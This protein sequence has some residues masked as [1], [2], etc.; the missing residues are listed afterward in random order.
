MTFQTHN[1]K[2]KV[3]KRLALFLVAAFVLAAASAFADDS[4]FIRV[5]KVDG[6]WNTDT[7][8]AGDTAKFYVM[9][10]NRSSKN[11]NYTAAFRVY[12]RA[13]KDAGAP[14]SGTAMWPSVF[15]AGVPGRIVFSSAR[16]RS[17]P[18]VDTTGFLSKANFGAVNSFN[19]FGCDGQ[20]V[21]TVGITQ[22]ANDIEQTAIAPFDS[23]VAYKFLIVTRKEDNGKAICFDSANAYP[24]TNTWKWAPFNQAPGTPNAF[25]DWSGPHCYWLFDPNAQPNQ[26]PVLAPIGSQNVNENQ[27]LVVVANANDPDGPTPS[28]TASPLPAGAGFVDNGNGTAQLT[29]TPT[30]SQSGVYNV[31]FVASDGQL[32]DS[33]LVQITV[34]NVNRPP[35]LD[36]IGPQAVNEGVNLTFGISGT[37]PDGGQLT[38]GAS[39][40]PTGA[41]F[42]GV[43]GT[44]SWTPA[45][46]QAGVYNVNFF[47]SDGVVADTELVQITVNNVNRPPVLAA[48][49]AKNATV[50]VNLSFGVSGSD[51]DGTIPALSAS[52]LA[53]AN[54]TDNGDGTGTFSF[55]PDAGQIGDHNVT[56]VASDGSLAD[57]EVVTITVTGV[58]NDAPTLDPIGSKT[59]AEGDQLQFFISGTDPNSDPLTFSTGPLPTGASFQAGAKSFFWQPGYDQAGVYNVL[60]IVSDGTLSDS[61]LVE[62]TVTNTNRPPVLAAI[63]AKS[64]QVGGTLVFN[65]A[66]SDVDGTIP[67]LSASALANA[68]LTDNGNGT[69]SYSFTPDA[70]Q[71]GVHN[72]TFVASDG[73]LADSE[74]VEITVTPKSDFVVVDKDTLM[75][76]ATINSNPPTQIV[77][78]TK[79]SDNEIDYTASATVT[80]IEL[81]GA[82]GTTPG[83]LFVAI[84]TSGLDVGSYHDSVRVQGTTGPDQWIQVYLTITPCPSVQVSKAVFADT[85]MAGEI[86]T[87]SDSIDITSTGAQLNFQ[88]PPADGFTFPTPS[89]VTPGKLSFVFSEQFN[90]AGTYQ[91]CFTVAATPVDENVACPSLKE[92]CVNIV[93]QQLP[94][95]SIL[96]SDTLL[97]FT[98][99]QDDPV[100]TPNAKTFTV[101]SSNGARN[102]AFEVKTPLGV[103]WISFD[104]TG[105]NSGVFNGTTSQAVPVQVRPAGL[106]VGVHTAVLAVS[107]TDESVCD[108]KVRQVTVYLNV[109]RRASADTVLVENKPAVPGQT[110]AVPVNFVNSCPLNSAELSL[111]F[112]A[113][114]LHLIAVMYGGSKVDYV[115]DKTETI[116]NGAGTVKL[117]MNVGAQSQVPVGFGNWATLYFVVRPEANTGFYP[118]TLASCDCNNPEFMRDCGGGAESQVPEFVSGGVIVDQ[119]ENSVCGYVVDPD[120]VEIPGAT[121]HLYG[122]FPNG[123]PEMTATT[124]AIGSFFFTGVTSVPFDLYAYADGY[125]PNTALDQNFNAKGIKIVLTPLDHVAATSQWVDYYCDAN[126][127]FQAALP[128]GSV[129]EAKTP[130]GLLVGQFVVTTAGKYGFMPVY[131]ANGDFG[132]DGAHAGDVISFFVNG[133][134]A[135]AT[136]NTTYPAEY[137]KVQVCL[138]YGATVTKE[139]VLEEGWNLVSWNVQTNST[140]ITDVLGPYMSCIDVILG[141]EQGGLTYDPTLPEFSTLWSVDH[142]SGYWIKVKQGCQVTLHLEGLPVPI[143]TPI[144]VTHGWNLVSYLPPWNLNPAY[145]LQS[146]YDHLQFAYGWNGGIEVFQPGS[147]F[148]T[149]NSMGTCSGYWVK[150]TADDTLIYP[151]ADAAAGWIAPRAIASADQ[152]LSSGDFTTP[153]WVNLYGSNLRVDGRTVGSGSVIEAYSVGS[154]AKVGSFT[155]AS[156]GKFGFMPVYAD[157]QSSNL[158]P[159]D[160]FYLKVDGVTTNETFTW[161]SNGDRVAV[162]A[163]TS[164]NSSGTL[165]DGFSL[166]QNYPNPFNPTT[167][168]SFSVPVNTRA[169]IEIYNVLGA[170]VAVPFDE[171]VVAGEHQVVWD[172][173]NQNGE[174]VSSGIYLYKLVSDRYSEAR[175]MML[176][177]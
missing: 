136:G 60:F 105:G 142:L 23:G 118:I 175:K 165:P 19:C 147:E 129:V 169:R 137:A 132:D 88:A 90:T 163:L 81:T 157:A 75:Y 51:L 5:T 93:V 76:T 108:P 159:G 91:R 8:K 67:S 52:A 33:E 166:E 57:S 66:A 24:P 42:D 3:M 115:T 18:L 145:A 17:G 82:S 125:Y 130:G 176:L 40:L 72:V 58:A 78:V 22:A 13:S 122:D 29:W 126:T 45:F 59:V 138:E 79:G 158:K 92:V 38:Y 36:P 10:G 34:N 170:L 11:Y 32:A 107:S 6:L 1:I 26:A 102:F 141:F 151:E 49:G 87:V 156:D 64:V 20:G 114:A 106:S 55:T 71:V 148:N 7:I 9:V 80:W 117:A 63:G 37:D 73:S 119:L 54:F 15:T 83:Q 56:F 74:V 100:G 133:G 111:T 50:G 86:S 144:P 48:I 116:D 68:A 150:I 109:T 99:V 177:K 146:I 16:P 84:N 30:F 96:T 155:M 128:V 94:C 25:P 95:V 164:S 97:M 120:G 61:E 154:D 173:R 152:S 153:T 143:A 4:T 35:V 127:Y 69:G 112:D 89:G 160:K 53:N 14:G 85:I 168:I 140:S 65:V 135:L 12:S 134:Q 21:D 121:V 139:C 46:N 172:G 27:Q 98:A 31:L 62:I 161:T 101:S 41:T 39:P 149:L 113:T 162:S 167:T 174:T 77:N 103:D 28:I 110:V 2:E 43:L 104:T 47:V 171:A 44:F 124:S 70:G 131:R 123:S